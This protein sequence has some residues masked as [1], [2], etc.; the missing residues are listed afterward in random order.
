MSADVQTLNGVTTG[1]Y[2]VTTSSGTRHEVDL[3]EHTA[4]RYPGVGH[5]WA[6]LYNDV[7]P[8]GEPMEYTTLRTATVGRRMCISNAYE[9]RVST[10]VVSIEAL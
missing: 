1:R 8:D 7:T 5:E 10:V 3:D 6:G 2:V 4:T 9:W